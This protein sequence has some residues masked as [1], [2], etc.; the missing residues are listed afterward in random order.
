LISKP[1][2][3]VF[4]SCVLS[5][6]LLV[7]L[8]AR[9]TQAQI[10][11]TAPYGPGGTWNLYEHRGFLGWER[12]PDAGQPLTWLEAHQDA[13]N[14]FEP[15]SGANV[16]GHLTAFS[17]PTAQEENAFVANLL[18]GTFAGT[19]IGLTDNEAFG[20]GEAGS[21]GMAGFG[22][23][24][25]DRVGWKWTSGE[26]FDFAAWGTNNPRPDEDLGCLFSG[27]TWS[28]NYSENS[29]SYIIE[30]E[31]RSPVAL[32]LP[33]RLLPPLLPGPPPRAGAFAIREVANNG[34]IEERPGYQG[35]I[36]SAI[37][38]LQNIGPD[39]DVRNYYARVIDFQ[40]EAGNN[41]PN[42]GPNQPFEVL[43]RG[44][45]RADRLDDFAM[46]AHGQILIPEGQGGEWTFAVTSDDGYE[47]YIRG[48][49]FEPEFGT[50]VTQYGSML[51]PGTRPANSDL[52]YVSLQPGVHDIELVYYENELHASVELH[53]APGRKERFDNSFA[54]I[55]A[56]AQNVQ[57]YPPIVTE[58][59]QF[60]NVQRIPNDPGG[61]TPG[62]QITSLAQ[63]KE[64]INSPDGNDTVAS[65]QTAT[66]NFDN[67]KPAR[68]DIINH[69][70]YTQDEMA[71][72]LGNDVALIAQNTILVP[73]A[74]TYTLGFAVL[75]GGELTIEGAQFSES[76]GEGVITGDGQSLA[77]DRSL[78][79]GVAFA[80]VDL[81][82]GNYS[83][84]FLTFNRDG[85]M[86]AEL[87]AAPG[88][89]PFFD[90]GAFT[91]LSP[92][93]NFINYNRPAGLQ[94]VPEPSTLWSAITG[95][96]LT[97]IATCLHRRRQK[98]TLAVN[99]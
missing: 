63:A 70:R 82:P 96:L 42:F 61:I 44:D 51:F 33:P 6:F 92:T 69:G 75:D 5:W 11:F 89:V 60:T 24:P 74:G 65:F 55:G 80:A 48:A 34:P 62:E 87:F 91:L 76:F 29:A 46:I 90:T 18:R 83:I 4:L 43:Q 56:P 38:S 53:A 23:P 66:V 20:G 2:L 21:N 49:Q 98:K 14:R 88:R 8:S 78:A 13:I 58:P 15:F 79:D 31:T 86:S 30:Y 9:P 7:I 10:Y 25:G 28:T 59:F 41:R 16:P 19:W 67:I 1:R 68:A 52:G 84:E 40:A 54:L 45:V 50:R 17:G 39:A 35:F 27:A 72:G 81:L 12:F 26:V 99:R 85:E 3:C 22:N 97:L 36:G 47:L 57:G 94:L 77:L 93:P 73:R 37:E 71:I 95:G 64:L 32:T